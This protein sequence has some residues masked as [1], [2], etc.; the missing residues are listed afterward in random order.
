M[1]IESLFFQSNRTVTFTI[2]DEVFDRNR[3]ALNTP[4]INGGQN[5]HVFTVNCQSL[6]DR[7]MNVYIV[8]GMAVM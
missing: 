8:H 4:L 5:S 7:G 2:K 3:S 1:F 6:T